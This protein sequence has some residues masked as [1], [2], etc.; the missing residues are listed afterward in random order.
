M[1]PDNFIIVIETV[2]KYQA[3]SVFF[4]RLSGNLLSVFVRQT[5]PSVGKKE[6]NIQKTLIESAGYTPNHVNEEPRR[7][8]SE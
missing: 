3:A 1:P 8:L 2:K 5:V 7:A 6:S 4:V